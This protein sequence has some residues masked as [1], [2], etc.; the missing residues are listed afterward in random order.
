M[1]NIRINLQ[2]ASFHLDAD[3]SVA[4]TG[5]TGIFG[6]SGSGK[7]SLLRVIAGLESQAS[8]LVQVG[9]AVWQNESSYIPIPQRGIGMVFQE[10]S[11]FQHLNVVENLNYGI[12]RN[13][14]TVQSIEFKSICEL[15]DL[16][17]LLER[18]PQTLSGGE[19]QRVAIARALL[20]S[21]MLLLLDEP[22]SALDKNARENLITYLEKIFQILDI[23]VFYV[24]HSSEEIA[25]LAD[26]LIL[27]DGG[28]VSAFGPIEE[29]LSRMDSPLIELDEAFSVLECS[30]HS[31]NLPHLT[32]V[33]SCGGG[34]LL[35][36]S[37]ITREIGQK[38]KLRILARDVSLC[39]SKPTDS[40]ILNI[41][42]AEVLDISELKQG[43][44]T[45]KLSIG[46]AKLLAKVSD[47]SAKKLALKPSLRLYAQIK[48]AA[49]VG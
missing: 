7:T 4:E 20:S 49:L 24:S 5:V 41:L 2:K 44:R 8:G 39:L 42:N 21:P 3:F 9:E 15:L 23:P 12:K 25:R 33:E 46:G 22:L 11:L 38:V 14:K 40:S 36:I 10:P 17:R 35:H 32:S 29:V 45:V 1:I 48:A 26:N 28:K 34:E 19:K 18:N 47:Y 27:M 37:H 30:V 6:P 16:D 31:Y 13:R 43:S